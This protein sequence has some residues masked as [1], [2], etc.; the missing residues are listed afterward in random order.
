MTSI[1]KFIQGIP[2]AELHVHIEGTLEPELILRIAKR[3]NIAIRRE[4]LQYWRERRADEMAYCFNNLQDFLNVY[5]EGT[6]VLL[7]ERDFYEMTWAYLRKASSQNVAHAEIFFDPQTHTDRD[8]D[9]GK[10]I[11]GI[12]RAQRD[13]Q[14]RLGISSK[15]IMCFLRHLDEESAMKT[16]DSA[17]KYKHVITAVGLDSSEVGNPP[18]KFQHVF[19]KARAEGFKAVAHAGEEGPAEYVWEALDVL[20]VSR[21]DHGNRAIDDDKLVDVL[22]RRGI[23]LTMCPLSNLKLKVV[24]DLSMHPMRMMME[25]GLIVTVNSDDPA[26]FGGYVNENYAAIANALN[27]SKYEITE[28]AMNSFTASYMDEEAKK[29]I[30]RKIDAY[31]KNSD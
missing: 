26:Y 12:T 28:L 30:I 13:G 16:L 31:Y 14:K 17:L 24:S 23:P 10:V 18:S 4:V 15:L 9:F 2:K 5:Y 7:E 19:G 27:L 11:D 29:D 8:V 20:V 21:I 22:V 25:R 6:R 3:N 1:E